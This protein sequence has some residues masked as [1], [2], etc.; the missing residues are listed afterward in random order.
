MKSLL[1]LL[2]TIQLVGCGTPAPERSADERTWSNPTV[3]SGGTSKAEIDQRL[4]RVK[5]RC[6]RESQKIIVPPPACSM[7]A[8]S[9]CADLKG[10]NLE[11]CQ[12]QQPTQQ[13]DHSPVHAAKDTQ[14]RV[15]DNCMNLA[16]W[17]KNL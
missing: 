10:F 4:S 2:L 9:D 12:V 15:F 7:K 14:A 1:A 8:V 13:C 5:E 11:W 17:V 6:D 16:G 3:D